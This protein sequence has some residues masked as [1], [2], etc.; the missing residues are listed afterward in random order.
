M[1]K[2]RVLYAED[3]VANRKLLEVKLEREGIE[4]DAV[5]NG[6]LAVQMYA[7]KEYDAVVLDQYM[8]EMDGEEVAAYIRER[9]SDIPLI[10]VTSDDSLKSVLLEAGFSEVLVKPLRGDVAV[11]RIKA[12]F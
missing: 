7:E 8:P 1:R 9:S 12:Y 11:D 10:A 4:C 5:E 6:K 3:D 2:K